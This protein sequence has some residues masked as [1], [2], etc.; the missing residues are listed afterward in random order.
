METINT[1]IISLRKDAGLSQHPVPPGYQ[2]VGDWP[3]N[4]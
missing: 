4:T 2:P 3:E 1:R